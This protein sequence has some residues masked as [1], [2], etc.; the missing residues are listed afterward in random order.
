MRKRLFS[1]GVLA[2]ALALLML[3]STTVQAALTNGWQRVDG[4]T[5]FDFTHIVKQ[6]R[7]GGYIIGGVSQSSPSG[8]KT[9]SKLG[10]AD[11]FVI[12]TGPAG[13]KEWDRSFGGA[14]FNELVALQQTADGGYLL[15]G[16]SETGVSGNKTDAGYGNR[17]YW[18]VK[19]D[20]NG[21][22]QWDKAFGGSELEFL[23]SMEPTR[24]GGFILGGTSFSGVSG[25]RTVGYLGGNARITYGDY[26][27]V[28][29][30]A[31][32]NK[33]WDKAF[34]RLFGNFAGVQQTRDGGYLI[35]S[36][37]YWL[38]KLDANANVQ[39][40]SFVAPIDACSLSAVRPTFD[41]GYITG[42]TLRS[43]LAS[44]N[45]GVGFGGLDYIIVKVSST[46]V[47]QWNAVYGG[48]IDD[49]L[50]DINQTRD[51]G[52]IIGGSSAS[53]VS[54]NKTSATFGFQDCWIVKVNRLGD[55]QWER[56]F[57]GSETDSAASVQQT[58]DGGYIIGAT[59]DSFL[60]GN[61]TLGRFG[62]TDCWTIKFF[63]P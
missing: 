15:A 9:S 42:G 54:G 45:M 6:T 49:I 2:C 34:R 57:G 58:R 51:G 38:E 27:L 28:K 59:S 36:D 63:G 22:K 12:K 44:T 5:D 16:T 43:G 30:D 23:R 8:N 20:S 17:D 41:G 32:G 48:V 53:S 62:E 14:G 39:W 40:T 47:P 19:L 33:K 26:W 35:A 29:I 21:R 18:L 25:N 37:G 3:V 4:G 52:Y 61:K 13:R 10:A 56:T 24:D 31:R 55:K 50:Q 46:G 7:D 60:T 1:A 11:Y